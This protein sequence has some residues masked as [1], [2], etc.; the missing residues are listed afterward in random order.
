MLITTPRTPAAASLSRCHSISRLPPASSSGLG[1]VSVSGR[2]RSPRPA[3]NSSAFTSTPFALSLVSATSGVEA[4]ESCFGFDSVFHQSRNL[5][6]ERTEKLNRSTSC[7][8]FRQIALAHPALQQR[9]EVLQ[10]GITRCHVAYVLPHARQ[11]GEV[12]ALAVA[13]PQAAEDAEHFQVPLQAGE[14]EPAL[15]ARGIDARVERAGV[16]QV[17]AVRLGPAAHACVVPREVAV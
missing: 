8:R 6:P 3:A 10:F 14:I 13:I 17:L 5:R 11:I 15:P 4:H 16:E 2:M 7:G 9:E 1:V 12:A